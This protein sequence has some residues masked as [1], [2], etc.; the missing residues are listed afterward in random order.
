M[1][2]KCLLFLILASLTL[3]GCIAIPELSGETTA[4][5]TES[6]E[7]AIDGAPAIEITNFAGTI[8]VREGEP[9]QIAATMTKQSRLEDVAAAE[10]QLAEVTLIVEETGSGARVVADG[11]QNFDNLEEVEIGLTA[12][13]EV[14]VPPGADLTLNLGAGEI[15]LEQPTGDVETNSGAGEA[16]AILPADASFRLVVNGGVADVQS[17]FAG[18]PGGGVAADI[19]TTVGDNPTQTL[20]FHLGAGEVRLEK[21]P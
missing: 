11:P 12:L 6:A 1:L 3:T 20:T 21:A 13:L 18:V 14:T 9:G 17:E 19:D 16:T 8:T 15:T 5:G 10:A 7:L 2:R 4:E